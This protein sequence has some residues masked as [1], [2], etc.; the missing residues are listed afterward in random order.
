MSNTVS[1]P[2]EPDKP[3]PLLP[4]PKPDLVR[5][6]ARA[7]RKRAAEERAAELAELRAYAQSEWQ[8]YKASHPFAE[9]VAFMDEYLSNYAEELEAPHQW[10]GLSDAALYRIS[11]DASQ[12]L[13]RLLE[14]GCYLDAV[15]TFMFRANARSSI[16]AV[17]ALLEPYVG[18]SDE[19]LLALFND[20]G[21]TVNGDRVF[22]YTGSVEK[23]RRADYPTLPI[24]AE[25]EYR[26]M[27]A[28]E[29]DRLSPEDF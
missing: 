23:E 20:A 11:L 9:R 1:R 5:D 24:H 22:W 7:M 18:F 21:L 4:L 26:P 19:Q 6:A 14:A 28:V 13:P 27:L 3:A 12:R 17:K 2:F 15:Q 25:R 8:A 10:D 29:D 16:H